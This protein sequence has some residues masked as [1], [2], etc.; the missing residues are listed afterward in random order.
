MSVDGY[1][2]LADLT[3]ETLRHVNQNSRA[4]ISDTPGAEQPT[5]R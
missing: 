1:P 5:A 4:A 3:P 2:T